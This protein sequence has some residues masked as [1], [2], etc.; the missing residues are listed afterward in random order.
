M[1]YF[2]RENHLKRKVEKLKAFQFDKESTE[3]LSGFLLNGEY[4]VKVLEEYDSDIYQNQADINET[5]KK[6]SN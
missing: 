6:K 5:D 3:D 2:L 4:A 1:V